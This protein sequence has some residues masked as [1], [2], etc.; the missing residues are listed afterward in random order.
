MSENMNVF[1]D[2]SWAEPWRSSEFPRD[3]SALERRKRFGKKPEWDNGWHDWIPRFFQF[4]TTYTG[5]WPWGYVIYRTSF[6]TT[7]DQDW[8]AAIDKLDRYCHSQML[9]AKDREHFRF[10]PNIHELVREGY[11]N[12]I[13]QDPNLEGA[14]VDVIR[15]RH[16]KWV[17]RRGFDLHLG[18]PRFDYCLFLDDRAIRSI[19]ASSEPDDNPG[20]VGYVSVIDCEFDPN[21]PENEC[22]EHYDGSLRICLT[23]L[24]QF[25]LSCENLTTGEQQWGDWGMERPG[26]VI[27]TDG[28]SSLV[29]EEDIFLCPSDYNLSSRSLY[30][31]FPREKPLTESQ[32][33]ELQ[34][35]TTWDSR[36]N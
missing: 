27:Y 16:I 30:P 18:I 26:R 14:S 36:T 25:A 5:G 28:Y 11:Q 9:L 10:Q 20:L 31:Q 34:R 8:A 6:M 12:V 33:N 32:Y 29:E 7:S 15:K 19:L 23:D 22:S 2:D 1:H 13:V 35:S 24:F 4:Q 21:D 17:E 3:E